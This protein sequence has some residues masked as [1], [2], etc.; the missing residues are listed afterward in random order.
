MSFSKRV[1]S[2]PGV[3]SLVFG[4]EP[5]FRVAFPKDAVYYSRS[6]LYVLRA[7]HLDDSRLGYKYF[8]SDLVVVI[9]HRNGY[10]Y[11]T[12]V[13]DTTK[14]IRLR[15]LC[16]ALVEATG[17][18]VI[19]KKLLPTILVTESTFEAEVQ[20]GR[21]ILP[22]E[23]D[24]V[25][26]SLLR[27][28]K[29]FIN[30]SGVLN[31]VAKRVAR[32]VHAF[33]IR[34]G[35]LTAVDD[36]SQV[37]L[38]S[39]ERFLRQWPEKYAS[40]MPMIRYLHAKKD[41]LHFYRS[42][43]FMD[44]DDVK[45]VYLAEKM[46][47]QE[48]GLYCGVTARDEP[49]ITEWMD[50]FF[51]KTLLRE[52]SK[53][54]Y[55]GGAEREGIA[56]FCSKL[57]PYKPDYTVRATL[58][59]PSRVT[60]SQVNIR[61]ASHY[62]ITPLSVVYRQAYNELDALGER[63]TRETAHTF[64]SHFYRRQPDLFFVAEVNGTIVGGAV[65]AIQPWWDGNHLVEGEI[66]VDPEYGSDKDIEKNLLKQL[67]LAARDQYHVVAW[68]TLMPVVGKHAFAAYE[69]IGFSEMPYVRAITADMSTMLD[70]LG[71]QAH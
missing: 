62:D 68:D 67:L 58:Y 2:I 60:N 10:T 52:G 17:Y 41:S 31:P 25:A 36:I 21:T 32:K 64:I 47:L 44:G 55:L 53:I 49:G 43:V 40:Y 18:Q 8:T 33:E 16:D 26:E 59:R 63:W 23:D 6:W 70:R 51:F 54:V 65:A 13:L 57:I 5:L 28:D 30:K 56:H 50:V 22:L 38:S 1:L 3:S 35:R 11:V 45:A 14:G 9:G 39:V 69:T 71:E 66:F 7:S 46:S 27:L 34:G 12:P 48:I 4:D 42:M 61:L 37:P 29:L 19:L 24:S 20:P 15:E